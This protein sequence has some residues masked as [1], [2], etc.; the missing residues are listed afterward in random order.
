MVSLR[1]DGK[2]V[3]VTGAGGGLGKTYAIE[4]AKRGAKVVVND[5]GG[6]AHGTDSSTSMADKVVKEIK[7]AG[8]IAV[9]NYDSVEFGEKLVKTA[10]D[11]F[12]RIDIVINNAGI[13]RDKSF[14]KINDIDW[15]L[16]Q[17]VHLKGA[18]SVSQA[19]WPYMKKQNYGRIIVT[20]SNSGVYGNFG[21][22]NYAAAKLG[23]IGLSNT[24][25]IEGEKYNIKVN[26][27]I[28]T[29]GSRLTMTAMPE[30]M[31][32]ALKPEFVTPLVIYMAHE[33][34]PHS[35][36]IYE[37]GAGWYG[38]VQFYRSQG[39]VIP[40]ATAEDVAN[41]WDTISCMK[42]AKHYES[43]KDILTDLLGALSEEKQSETL[44]KSDEVIDNIACG[45]VFKE[46]DAAIKEKPE[47]VKNIKAIIVYNILNHGKSVANIVLDF[48]NA[49]YSVYEGNVKNGKANATVTVE[50]ED[51]LSIAAG[52]LNAQKAFMSGKLKVKGNIML[53]QKLQG[54]LEKNKPKAKL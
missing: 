9:P 23:L 39:K 25:A 35:G 28:P 41:N 24:L 40:Q 2:V 30:D 6:S 43:G 52:T 42:N 36:G 33:S 8:G 16:I 51:F 10:I 54:I 3:L 27:L 48:K 38:Q 31:V 49:P 20:S 44:S 34:F 14:Q 18:F 45:I 5:L 11:N 4:F 50:D 15:D 21:Q 47:L 46:I 13:L 1:F 19:A 53:L 26:S 12:G 32:E 7:N 37:A 29:A 17:K 22:A